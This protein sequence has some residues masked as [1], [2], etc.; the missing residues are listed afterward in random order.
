MLNP[1]ATG[2]NDAP[3]TTVGATVE[4]TVL[5]TQDEAMGGLLT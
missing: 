3:F 4:A 5:A 2:P 1:V